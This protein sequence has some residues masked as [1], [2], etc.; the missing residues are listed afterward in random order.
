[1]LR[2][3]RLAVPEIFDRETYQFEIGKGVELVS[4][5]DVT[6]IATGLMVPEALAAADQ[7]K[8]EGICARVI[9]MATIKPIDAEIIIKAARETGG[10]V[11]AEEHNI[12]G[13]LGSAVA[14]VLCEHVPVP[15]KRV[16][17]KDVFGQSGK[18]YELLEL[19]GLTAENIAKNAKEVIN[20][21]K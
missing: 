18:P 12:I 16:G 3:G 6:I 1:Y 2:F 11:T 4:G 21:K 10:I 17:T 14:E 8:E 13:G 5:S 19:Y 7:L 20:M 9:N 15:M